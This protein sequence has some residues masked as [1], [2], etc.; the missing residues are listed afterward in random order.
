[1]SKVFAQIT[2]SLDG[3]TTGPNDGAAHPL[4]EGG[5]DLHR[6]VL[7]PER[8][9]LDEQVGT[10]M[11]SDAGAFVIGR[12]MA[13]IGIPLWGDDGGFGKSCFIVTHRAAPRLVKG[14]TTF[15]YITAGLEAALTAALAAANG[16]DVCIVGGADMVRQALTLGLLDELRLDI[17][18]ILL[19]SGRPLFQG[20]TV[21]GT[22]TPTRVLESPLATHVTYRIQS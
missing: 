22:L 13:D 9:K 19:G 14:S 1:M 20:L 8:T 7:A 16:R 21:K 2:V 15:T 5:M 3:Y 17:A 11:L 6:W 10:E 4:G 18:P 12:R